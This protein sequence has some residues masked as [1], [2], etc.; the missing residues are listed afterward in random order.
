MTALSDRIAAALGKKTPSEQIAALIA[1]AEQ[2]RTVAECD[3]DAAHAR[4]L[5]PTSGTDVA[6]AAEARDR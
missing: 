2:A 6:A 4:A 5:D 1:E 3:R